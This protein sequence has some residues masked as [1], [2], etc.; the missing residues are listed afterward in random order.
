M[1]N[2]VT[3]LLITVLLLG[4]V[5]AQAQDIFTEYP[6]TFITGDEVR[7]LSQNPVIET[8][9]TISFD[10]FSS[11]SLVWGVHNITDA[12]TGYDLMSN[13]ST[14]QVWL[15][16][17]NPDYLHAVFTSS[18]EFSGAYADRTSLYF[19]STDAGEN[20]FE[21]GGVP[22]NNGTDGRS[23]FPAIFGTSTGAAVIANHNN[24]EGTTTHSKVFIDNTPFEYN[25]T[26]FDPGTPT[27]GDAIWPRIVLL[28]N[29]DGVIA[30]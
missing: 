5:T 4:F 28:D 8:T 6:I 16:L 29:D 2:K 22:V 10:A 24:S 18:Q 19:G 9:G 27:A 3:A 21:L 17:N 20:W 14:Q 7:D 13:A 1:L 12:K 23:G 25:F 11:G 30:S 15:D 26:T